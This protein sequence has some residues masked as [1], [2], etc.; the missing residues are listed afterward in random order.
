MGEILA[1]GLTHYPPLAWRDE[2]MA[3]IM[4]RMLQNPGLPARLR[5]PEGWPPPMRSFST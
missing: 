1:I 3:M 4:D 5:T 2:N